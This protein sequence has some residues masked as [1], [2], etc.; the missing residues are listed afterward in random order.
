M[1]VES[2][3]AEVFAKHGG[4]S[5]PRFSVHFQSGEVAVRAESES[6]HGVAIGK[7]K[8]VLQKWALTAPQACALPQ[9]LNLK[10]RTMVALDLTT[11]LRRGELEALRWEHLNEITGELRVE[12]H[13]YRG[14]IDEPKTEAG[15]RKAIIPA[16]VMNLILA[17]N[18]L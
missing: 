7:L 15:R 4:N 2:A 14:Y 10:P 9:D 16:D 8:F 1:G 6:R 5:A 13:H 18:Q 11:G 12:Q 17:L 3:G